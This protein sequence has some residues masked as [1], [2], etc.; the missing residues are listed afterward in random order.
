MVITLTINF[1]YFQNA[2]K[3]KLLVYKCKEGWEPLCEFL[4]VEVPNVPFPH[5]NKAGSIFDDLFKSHSVLIRL[6]REAYVV[7]ASLLACTAVG[8]L[9]CL[10]RFSFF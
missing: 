2:P 8:V 5:K 6:K 3:D 9:L 7:I 10:K 4:G 1:I